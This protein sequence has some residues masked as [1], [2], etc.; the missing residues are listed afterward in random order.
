M[1][2]QIELFCAALGFFS[3]IPVPKRITWSPEHL[4]EA[5]RY[6]PL[7]G[8]LVGIGGAA[9]FLVFATILPPALAVL[10]SM[11]ATIRLT[12]AIHEDGLADSCDGFGAGWDR[13]QILAI[14]QDSHIGTYGVIGLILML[15]SKFVALSA[16]AALS[17]GSAVVALCIA[18]PLSRLAPLGLI[19]ALPYARN[20]GPSKSRPVAKPLSR[21]GL[22]IALVSGLLPLLLLD[23]VSAVVV[24][25]AAGGFTAWT[26]VALS[27]RLGGY[28]GDCLGA[29]Q[30][31]VELICYLGILA[32]W[33]YI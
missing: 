22:L 3:R 8:W 33:N 19:Q 30:Q 23:P 16:L 2:R 7:I 12:G 11:A 27:Q 14:M 25:A 24:V 31:G 18:H 17:P 9:V 21:N 26:A 15:L 5:A 20:D 6:L 13:K 4:R 1:R 28:T 32:V 10:I 29:T